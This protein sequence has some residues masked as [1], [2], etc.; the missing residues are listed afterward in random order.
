ME[1]LEFDLG[2]NQ[3]LSFRDVLITSRHKSCIDDDFHWR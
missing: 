1:F 2:S 3:R